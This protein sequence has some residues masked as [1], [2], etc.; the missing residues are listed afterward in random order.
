METTK[1]DT[2]PPQ[3]QNRQP[4]KESEMTPAPVFD[5]R[6]YKGSGK[7][8]GKVAVVTGGDS[9]IGRAV[10]I[11]Y[12]KEGADV[13]IVH[14]GED[15]DARETYEIVVGYG[16]RCLKLS[17]DLKDEKECRTVVD[18][19]VRHFDK[20][21][22]L[23]NNAGVQYPQNSILDITK[24]QLAHTFESNVFSQFY[25]TKAALTHM[26]RGGAIINT[27]SITAFEGSETLIDYSATKGAIL[28][29]T[30]SMALSLVKQGIRVNAVAPGPIWTPLIVSSFSA[31][32]VK[33]FGSTTP[34]QR[35][36]QP[37]EAA[38][39]YVFLA[40]GDSSYMTGQVLHVNGGKI[41]N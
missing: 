35:A 37:C 1:K 28:S 39:A 2:F 24:D 4:G 38:P 9:G 25:L 26:Q 34:M 17:A 11:A 14:L 33:T 29:F 12:A 18:E 15:D 21:D 32:E 7:L 6:N 20:I 30:R 10:A 23:V 16:V 40:S 31:E 8:T 3:H 13:A 36:G 22:I 27:T 19:V 41:I 5:D